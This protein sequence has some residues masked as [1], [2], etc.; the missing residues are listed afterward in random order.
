MHGFVAHSIVGPI[1]R[2]LR[3]VSTVQTKSPGLFGPGRKSLRTRSV[4]R[5]CHSPGPHRV[6]ISAGRRQAAAQPRRAV[7]IRRLR[8]CEVLVVELAAGKH[9]SHR[10]ILRSGADRVLERIPAFPPAVK[11]DFP[12]RHRRGNPTRGPAV[13]WPVYR[14]VLRM[15][16]QAGGRE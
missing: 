15:N 8:G 16:C 13:D 5:H 4:L 12:V 11:R 6:A 1:T 2:A 9:H 7:A 10:S 14:G 3:P